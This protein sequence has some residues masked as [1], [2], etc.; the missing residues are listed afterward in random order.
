MKET[1]KSARST[2]AKSKT[3]PGFTADERAAMK[4]HAEELKTAARRGRGA[5]KADGES[6]LLAKIAEM[7]EPDRGMAS[8]MSR[9]TP[10]RCSCCARTPRWRPRMPTCGAGRTPHARR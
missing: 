10:R 4:D 5:T 3:S 8:P 2:T 7:A 9:C 1:Q 6:D